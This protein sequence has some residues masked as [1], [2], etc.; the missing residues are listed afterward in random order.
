MRSAEEM[1][2]IVVLERLTLYNQGRP[3]G[4]KAIRDDLHARGEENAVPSERTI[5][6]ILSRH[7]LTHARTGWYEGEA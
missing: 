2:Q 7:G 5:G 3:C 4:A 6:R 1:E